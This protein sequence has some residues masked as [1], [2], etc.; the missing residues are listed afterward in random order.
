MGSP[1]E[2]IGSGTGRRLMLMESVIAA[3]IAAARAAVLSDLGVD[4][5]R[6]LQ[7]YCYKRL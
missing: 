2:M 1:L 5:I 7:G 6:G 4:S 3:A